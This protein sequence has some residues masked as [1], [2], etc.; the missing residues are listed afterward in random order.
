V[1][2]EPTLL[3]YDPPLTLP[4]LGRNEVAVDPET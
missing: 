1:L 4:F 2:G 3:G